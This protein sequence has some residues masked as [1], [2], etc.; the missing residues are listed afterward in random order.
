MV[1]GSDVQAIS[2]E[3]SDSPESVEE[4]RSSAR[5]C[6]ARS[7]GA[8]AHRQTGHALNPVLEIRAVY[9]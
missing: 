4:E 7:D 8:D 2:I 3:S 1:S 5:S 9:H 6:R